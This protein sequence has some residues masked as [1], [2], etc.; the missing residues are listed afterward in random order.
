MKSLFVAAVVTLLCLPAPAWAKPALRSEVTATSEIV[1]VGDFY[2]EAGAAADE[3]LFR[4]PDLGTSGTVSAQIVAERARAAGLTQAGT[5][6]LREVTVHR[7]SIVFDAHRLATLVA[8][9]LSRHDGTLSAQ[10][11]EVSFARTPPTL[12]ADPAAAQPIRIERPLWSRSDGRFDVVVHIAG[13]ARS[14][15]LTLSGVAREMVDVIAL[16]QPI[17]RGSILKPEDLTVIRLPRQR[18]PSRA[19]TSPDEIVGLAART[20]LRPGQPLSRT[21]FERPLIVARGEKVTLLYEMSGMKLTARGQAMS[22]GAE[23]D[24]IDVMNLQSRRIITGTVVARGQIRV[25]RAHEF[26]A[27]LQENAR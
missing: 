19:V 22:A 12:H 16:L 3:P 17:G 10:A 7:H 27:A 8:E 24:E 14:Q 1:T 4:A 15:T 5:D 26:V 9:T 18:V 23:G 2:D 11:L 20:T 25:G 6:G 13:A 21:D